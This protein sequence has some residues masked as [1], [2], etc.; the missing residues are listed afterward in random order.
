MLALRSS[1]LLCT[2][3]ITFFIAVTQSL[4][5]DG[6]VE[7]KYLGTPNQKLVYRSRTI[8]LSWPLT[9]SSDAPQRSTIRHHVSR[10]V[11]H[12]S[13]SQSKMTGPKWAFCHTRPRWFRLRT[14]SLKLRRRN[15]NSSYGLYSMRPSRRLS[16]GVRGVLPKENL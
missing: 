12:R 16:N 5:V 2:L 14:L 3:I 13:P 11:R 7:V 6:R 15:P 10:P 4:Q 1:L 8:P 9:S